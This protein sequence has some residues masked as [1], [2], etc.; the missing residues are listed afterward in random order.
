[1]TKD[2]QGSFLCC[3]QRRIAVGCKIIFEG[4]PDRWQVKVLASKCGAEAA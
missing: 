4:W 3:F 1:M 2:K